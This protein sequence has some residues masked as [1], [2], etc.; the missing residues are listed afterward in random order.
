MKGYFAIVRRTK[1]D[2]Y[3][4]EF[5]DIPGCRCE[6]PTVDD[7]FS[8]AAQALR[9]HADELKE[10]GEDLPDPRPAYEMATVAAKHAG[11]AA[12]CLMPP[13]A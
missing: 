6:A 11:V 10:K 2:D 13:V 5:P 4:V 9:E 1:Q 3:L 12:A 8:T 7:A